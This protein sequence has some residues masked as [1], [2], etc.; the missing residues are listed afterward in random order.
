M[1]KKENK[2]LFHKG[3]TA[4]AIIL[5]GDFNTPPILKPGEPYKM[6]RQ[7]MDNACKDC[8]YRPRFF[9]QVGYQTTYALMGKTH[10]SD[11]SCHRQ[12]YRNYE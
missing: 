9:D 11:K 6:I 2:N 12:I 8:R 10:F 3:S 4:D 5:G 1:K 7:F